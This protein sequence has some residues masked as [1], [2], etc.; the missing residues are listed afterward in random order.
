M[1]QSFKVFIVNLAWLV[2]QKI[3]REGGQDFGRRFPLAKRRA[4]A[5]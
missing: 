1:F 2:D 5:F 4:L 3:L